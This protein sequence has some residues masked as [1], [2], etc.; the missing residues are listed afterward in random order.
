MSSMN[1]Y[2]H[3]HSGDPLVHQAMGSSYT[4]V[5]VVYDNLDLFK[6]AALNLDAIRNKE[7]TP[8]DYGGSKGYTTLA[9]AQAGVDDTV[10]IKALLAA[11][12]A[13]PSIVPNFGGRYWKISET[14][15]FEQNQ[16]NTAAFA[17]AGLFVAAPGSTGQNLVEIACRYGQIYGKL[18]AFGTGGT[19]YSSR[20][21]VNGTFLHDSSRVKIEAWVS[22]NFKRNGF[23]IYQ[24]TTVEN[25]IAVILGA[26]RAV[27]C[28]SAV[29]QD[30]AELND[31]FTSSDASR[32][33][34]QGSTAQRQILT[35]TTPIP[36][37]VGI[38]DTVYFAN[39]PY[40]VTA[41]SGNTLTVYPWLP[42]GTTGGTLAYGHGAGLYVDGSNT[43]SSSYGLVEGFRCGS[44]VLSSGLYAGRFEGIQSQVSGC[45]LRMG[46]PVSSASWGMQ[47]GYF[48]SEST[49]FD[50]IGVSTSSYRTFL[51]HPSAM[52]VQT[53][54]GDVFGQCFQISPRVTAGTYSPSYSTFKGVEF[55]DEY[56][57]ITGDTNGVTRGTS[58]STLV[59]S[60]KPSSRFKTQKRTTS[61]IELKWWDA[62]DK[63]SYNNNWCST[64]IFGSGT[65]NGPGGIT[66]VTPNSAD[67]TSGITVNGGASVAIPASIYPIEI[68]CV[69]DNLSTKNW[70]VTWRELRP[71]ISVTGTFNPPSIGAG[72]TT[73]TTLTVA[74]AALGDIVTYSFSLS[75][76]GLIMTAYVSA[77]DTVTFVFQNPKAT[78]VD[79]GN[80]TLRVIVHKA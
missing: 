19:A 37:E 49:K 77:A 14:I 9:A 10:A 38:D 72:A 71:S 68:F 46:N 7:K 1:P 52:G 62:T 65:G 28:G 11:W 36:S 50:V 26:G 67:A 39:E 79:L 8:S 69:M 12:T 61:T 29:D 6:T 47:L 56:G 75:L 78:P 15:R 44:V 40:V 64:V 60:N 22:E 27:N 59:L 70:L 5:K 18:G 66:T 23:A 51:P 17:Y 32:T 20:G 43:A 4:V 74:G 21:W 31:T 45:A 2:N 16:L 13:D 30:T 63:L 55:R 58:I 24:P 76:D 25:N 33:G 35:M 42:N 53:S 57:P 73:I 3:C 80:G 41:A 54:D 34:S 48:H